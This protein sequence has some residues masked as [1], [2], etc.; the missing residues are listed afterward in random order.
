M[1]PL[2]PPPPQTPVGLRRE[3]STQGKGDG[4]TQSANNCGLGCLKTTVN[5]LSLGQQPIL[6]L[7]EHCTCGTISGPLV[8]AT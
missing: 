2:P 6:Q 5:M 8:Y 3:I 4:T 1:P 7:V